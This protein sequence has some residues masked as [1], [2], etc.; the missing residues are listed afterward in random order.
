[1]SDNELF[2]ATWILPV[3]ALY[4]GIRLERWRWQ[5]NADQ[6]Q[7]IESGGNLYKVFHDRNV[8]TAVYSPTQKGPAR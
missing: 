4:L 7:R 8:G 3:A 6:I 5:R 2:Y 1:M